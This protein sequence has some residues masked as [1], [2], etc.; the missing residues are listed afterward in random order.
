[1]RVRVLR[2]LL[3][4]AAAVLLLS[5]LLLSAAVHDRVPVVKC[6]AVVHCVRYSLSQRT[7]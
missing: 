6:V 2:V 4:A 5:L 7:K 1:M 3:L